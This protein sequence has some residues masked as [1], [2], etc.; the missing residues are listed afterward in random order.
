DPLRPVRPSPVDV[1]SGL[2][3]LP[4]AA[5]AP[6]PGV[7]GGCIP[8]FPTPSLTP[9]ALSCAGCWPHLHPPADSSAVRA[10]GPGCFFRL[11]RAFLIRPAPP[12]ILHILSLVYFSHSAC[13]CH[14]TTTLRLF[15][16]IGGRS[17]SSSLD[18][19]HS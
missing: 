14:A 17:L 7:L 10:A 1:P 4:R 12:H 9:S 16:L 8:L 18:K 11:E 13:V 2:Y 5:G 19:D 3:S 6:C 15:T